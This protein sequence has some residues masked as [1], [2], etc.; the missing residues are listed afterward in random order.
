MEFIFW[1]D[2]KCP[3]EGVEDSTCR[4]MGFQ[5]VVKQG[6][7]VMFQNMCPPGEADPEFGSGMLKVL[8]PHKY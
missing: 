8:A 5:G 3:W 6:L 2:E 4:T 1:W 7:E